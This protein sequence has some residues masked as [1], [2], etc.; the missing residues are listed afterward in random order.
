MTLTKRE[1]RLL[2]PPNT[3]VVCYGVFEGSLPVVG[4]SI[5]E[6]I[7]AKTFG[8]DS[9]TVAFSIPESGAYNLST[10]E[11]AVLLADDYVVQEH[12]W[13][14]LGRRMRQEMMPQ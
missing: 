3:A 11:N 9:D 4:Q 8:V 2:S 1:A 6:I 5:A 13:I 7:A 10:M 14:V 12:D